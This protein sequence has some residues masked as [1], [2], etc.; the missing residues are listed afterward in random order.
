MRDDLVATA[1]RFLAD[2]KVADAPLNQRVAFLERKGLTAEE[3]AE[4]LRPSSSSTST[5]TTAPSTSSSPPTVPQRNYPPLPPVVGRMESSTLV[6]AVSCVVLGSALG[7]S[8]VFACRQAAPWIAKR[9]PWLSWISDD[10]AIMKEKEEF[11]NQMDT[12]CGYHV[13]MYITS[14][15]ERQEDHLWKLYFV[16]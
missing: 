9:V 11:N 15:H 13:H 8:L 4:A 2:P 1:R 12:V 3:I 7:T 6:M 14:K 10:E 5:S 16:H